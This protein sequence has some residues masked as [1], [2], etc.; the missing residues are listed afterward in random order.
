MYQSTAK[1]GKHTD[2]VWQ[3]TQQI[4]ITTTFF[5]LETPRA[6]LIS[7]RIYLRLRLLRGNNISNYASTV[8]FNTR[9]KSLKQTP[10]L[11]NFLENFLHLLFAPLFS[12]KCTPPLPQCWATRIL[13]HWG[14]CNTQINI[15]EGKTT[16]KCFKIFDKY[17]SSQSWTYYLH[18][19][20]DKNRR[21]TAKGGQLIK[22]SNHGRV[23]L[24]PPNEKKGFYL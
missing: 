6:S 19:W 13:G 14:D 7:A 8:C 20:N 22:T 11:L 23:C 24:L 16:H 15:G 9:H 10:F 3:V 2:P 1:T 5:H 18:S 4:E 17:C 12:V 21:T